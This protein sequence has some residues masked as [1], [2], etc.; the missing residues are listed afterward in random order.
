MKKIACQT[1]F[2]IYL[3]LQSINFQHFKNPNTLP[4]KTFNENNRMH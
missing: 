1:I 2:T 3:D 4:V